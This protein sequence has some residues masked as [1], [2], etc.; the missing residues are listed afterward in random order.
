MLSIPTTSLSAKSSI[1]PVDITRKVLLAEVPRFSRRFISFKSAVSIITDTVRPSE[2]LLT[3]PAVNVTALPPRAV[4]FCIVMLDSTRLVW[5]TV[6]ENVRF[7]TPTLRSNTKL[8][9]SG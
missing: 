2:D 4:E 9:N 3:S 6:S 8:F 7:K 1:A 5:S